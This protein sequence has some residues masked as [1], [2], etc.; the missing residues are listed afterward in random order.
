MQPAAAS[1]GPAAGP[2]RG[3]LAGQ[4]ALV[5]G[6]GR[7]IGRAVAVALA[8]E[9]AACA[10]VSRTRAEIEETGALVRRHGVPVMALTADVT[11]PAAV[12]ALVEQ[13]WRGL[14]PVS[15]L[16]NNAGVFEPHEFLTTPDERWWAL[17]RAN[18]AGAV[19]CSRAVAG[20][21]ARAGR[22]GRIVNVSSVNGAFGVGWSSAY[23]AAK[24]ALDQLTRSLAVE[25]APYGVLVNGVAPGFIETAMAT[26]RGESDL[27]TDVFRDFYVGQRRIP[28]ARAGRPEEVAAAVVFFASPSCTYVTGQTLFVDGGLSITY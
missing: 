24:G 5:T 18:L 9:G 3:R 16:V 20:R 27:K 13:V 1:E 14:G 26:A 12:E 8:A 21:L 2:P 10:L 22:G 15:V 28:L 7:G 6:A 4:V 23:N 11:D 25:L 19:Y 17:L